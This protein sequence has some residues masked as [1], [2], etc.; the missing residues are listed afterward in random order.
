[1]VE[2]KLKSLWSPE[3]IAGWLRRLFPDDPTAMVEPVA[4][5]ASAI[6]DPLGDG[7]TSR[8]IGSQA[9]RPAGESE[10]DHR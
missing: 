4:R 5:S 1:M 8:G 7:N 6:V 9:S 2:D 3:Q 10:G